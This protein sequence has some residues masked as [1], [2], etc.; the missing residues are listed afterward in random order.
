MDST[1]IVKDLE[2]VGREV[3]FETSRPRSVSLPTLLVWLMS[4][5]Q[6]GEV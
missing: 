3:T 4:H 2:D 5:R 1:E 6:G